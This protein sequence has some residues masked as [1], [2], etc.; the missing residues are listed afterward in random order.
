MNDMSDAV[1]ELMISGL[2]DWL[3]ASDFAWAAYRFMGAE[4][5]EENLY[6]SLGL[7]RRMVEDGLIVIG[8]IGD[9][10]F[11]PWDRSLD[12]EL[13]EIEKDWREQIPDGGP[14][15]GLVWFNLTPKGKRLAEEI[16]AEMTQ[17]EVD[18]L[19]GPIF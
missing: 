4:E 15:L 12:E 18:D 10:G 7:I 11:E 5:P 19:F 6:V 9:D 2:D 16:Y 17:K 3:M 13:R 14:H 1:R 8:E